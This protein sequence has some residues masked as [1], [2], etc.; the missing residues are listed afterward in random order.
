MSKTPVVTS[1]DVNVRVESH[2]SNVP[3][4]ATEAFTVNLTELSAGGEIA[5]TGACARFADG[6]RADTNRPRTANR[7]ESSSN[8]NIQTKECAC[9]QAFIKV[10]C[11]PLSKLTGHCAPLLTH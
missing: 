5:N 7:I 1:V 6:N 2:L 4:M 10:S 3:S 11:I 9:D 8:T